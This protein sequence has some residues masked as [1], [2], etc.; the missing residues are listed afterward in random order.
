MKISSVALSTG[1]MME[2]ESAPVS[3]KTLLIYGGLKGGIYFKISLIKYSI[4]L[5]A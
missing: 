1:S 4:A 2:A 5:P 3:Y